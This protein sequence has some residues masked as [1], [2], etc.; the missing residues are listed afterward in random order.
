MRQL[1]WAAG[2]ISGTVATL[3]TTAIGCFIPLMLAFLSASSSTC[4]SIQLD[5][6]AYRVGD[7]MLFFFIFY[8]ANWATHFSTYGYAFSLIGSLFGFI[9]CLIFFKRVEMKKT[10]STDKCDDDIEKVISTPPLVQVTV[11]RPRKHASHQN[12]Q[13]I[14]TFL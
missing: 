8:G 12:E 10:L 9:F 2:S 14:S 3:P 1:F 5:A 13:A 7:W 4:T 11:K 6:A